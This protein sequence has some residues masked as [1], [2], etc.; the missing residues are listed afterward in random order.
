M[1]KKRS[2]IIIDK[3]KTRY[4]IVCRN[5]DELIFYTDNEEHVKAFQDQAMKSA[6]Q[7]TFSDEHTKVPDLFNLRRVIG[8]E[9]DTRA[10]NILGNVCSREGYKYSDPITWLDGYPATEIRK[11]RGCGKLTLKKI[12]KICEKIG[13]EL[14]MSGYN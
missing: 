6:A 5:I 8:D 2:S 7:V 11:T 10:F 3:T 13:I 9:L 4:K 12:K 14:D 1:K